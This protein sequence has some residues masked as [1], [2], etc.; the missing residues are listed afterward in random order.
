MK[1]LYYTWTE[2]MKDDCVL[3]LEDM[4]HTVKV[5]DYKF[6]DYF[7]DAN[8]VNSFEKEL[9]KDNYDCII[10]IDFIPLI[11]KIALRNKIKYISWIVDSP[12]LSL[13]CLMVFNPYNYIFH[14]D[15]REA[16]ILKNMGVSNIY[17]MPI[18]VNDKRLSTLLG[19][20]TRSYI[21][22]ISFMGNMYNEKFNEFDTI[23]GMSEYEKGF[24]EGII[25]SQLRIFGEDIMEEAIPQHIMDSILTRISLDDNEEVLIT[26][27]QI[28]FNLMRRKATV[29]ERKE[30]VKMIGDRWGIDLYT[31]SDTSDMPNVR[32]HGFIS[33]YENM[34]KMFFNS[35]ININITMRG[36]QS[37]SSLRNQDIMAAGGFLLSNYQSDLAD[38]YN[39]GEDLVMYYTRQDLADK[40]EYYLSHD[41]EREEIADNGRRKTLEN[42]SYYLA[43]KKIFSIAGLE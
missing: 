41:K 34:S 6:S 35:K 13:Y 1:I 24:L 22:D 20:Y 3:S 39:D 11:S 12:N 32:N 10:S 16:N 28:L 37:G 31:Q 4:G 23:V 18:G 26:K 14:F 38:M 43:W 33:Y 5:V 17:Y 36:I 19:G 40:I 15:S 25:R 8:F 42:N 21:N 27:K 2:I 9:F 30:I 29:I 7:K